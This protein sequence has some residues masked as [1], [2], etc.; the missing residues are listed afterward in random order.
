VG[1]GP[2]CP[3]QLLAAL[4]LS[5]TWCWAAA[6]TAAAA[7]D[8]DDDDNDNDCP[9]YMRRSVASAA[10]IGVF[11][12]RAFASG[13]IAEVGASLAVPADAS[14]ASGV[15]QHFVFGLNDTHETV[16]LG[17]GGMINHGEAP[18]VHNM[19][20]SLEQGKLA[21]RESEYCGP[22]TAERALCPMAFVA[23]ANIPR[24]T[25]LL[26]T[27]GG[28]EWFTDRRIPYVKLGADDE[29]A[30]KTSARSPPAGTVWGGRIPGCGGSDVAAR[31]WQ[32]FATRDYA[33]D[34]VVEVSAGLVLRAAGWMGTEL[35]P[36]TLP[37]SAAA[38]S[39]AVVE[40]ESIAL[41]SNGANASSKARSQPEPGQLGALGQGGAGTTRRRGGGGGGGA[42]LLLLGKGALYWASE[43]LLPGGGGAARPNLRAD[44]WGDGARRGRGGDRVGSNAE[45]FVAF[46]T[47][48]AVRA[49][50]RLWAGARGSWPPPMDEVARLLDHHTLASAEESERGRGEES[51]QVEESSEAPVL[52]AGMVEGGSDGQLVY[53]RA[54]SGELWI[55]PK[56]TEREL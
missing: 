56:D 39:T 20:V 22:P 21:A 11:A 54:D 3:R 47:V 33:P 34:E 7:A 26:V 50:E 46:R 2:L 19:W 51:R 16:M 55:P 41:R 13:D 49:G 24:G 31:G 17:L 38:E 9:V 35:E 18:N 36:F 1:Q 53:L 5:A 29:N 48:G 4:L 32:A 43:S 12:G 45:V 15:L 27:Y 40:A 14:W 42:G 52:V 6:A 23:S 25:Q 10:G 8:D 44:W 30:E 37:L 28:E